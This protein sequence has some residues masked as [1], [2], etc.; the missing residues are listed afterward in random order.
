MNEFWRGDWGV[1]RLRRAGRG[2]RFGVWGYL[3]VRLIDSPLLPRDVGNGRA[4]IGWAWVL[5]ARISRREFAPLPIAAAS[6]C[7]HCVGSY[8]W[9][10]RYP[11]AKPYM[12]G[13]DIHYAIGCS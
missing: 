7:C 13:F 12:V 6:Y 1:P 8:L 11:G 3:E 10:Y 9:F 2:W 4:V 5:G